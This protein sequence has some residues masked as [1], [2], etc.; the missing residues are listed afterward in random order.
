MR[1][2]LYLELIS[3]MSFVAAKVP[4]VCVALGSDHAELRV[5]NDI[6]W[7]LVEDMTYGGN[8][9]SLKMAIE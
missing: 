9:K 2:V 7:P 1:I 5:R 3:F 6:A 4:H 8:V